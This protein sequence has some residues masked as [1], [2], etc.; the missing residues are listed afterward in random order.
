MKID[1][2]DEQTEKTKDSPGVVPSSSSQD[3][4]VLKLTQQL[5]RQLDK[6]AFEK[7]YAPV[8]NILLLVGAGAFL[9]ASIAMPNLPQLLKPFLKQQSENEY[10]VWKRYN[11]PYLKRTLTRL[12]RQ[13]LIEITEENGLQVVKITDSG[14]TKII[15]YGIDSLVIKKPKIWN[16]TWYLVSYD[17]PTDLRNIGEA[18]R[19]YLQNWNFYPIHESVMLHA[20]PCEEE[21]ELLRQ[22]L[23]LG[24]YVRIF[25]VSK[26]ENDKLFRDFFDV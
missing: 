10:E 22:S 9:A 15:K 11:I 24:E 13:K 19:E 2:L 8:K 26:I 23:G 4:Y 20:Y 16:R 6:D 1:K 5:T 21:V 3:E 25:T 7:K 12:E 17:F 18:F 14:K